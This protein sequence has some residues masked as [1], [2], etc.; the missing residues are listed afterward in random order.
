MA[1]CMPMP[2]VE[3]L[4]DP[5]RQGFDDPNRLVATEALHYPNGPLTGATYCH[6]P[7]VGQPARGENRRYCEPGIR[8]EADD[9]SNVVVLSGLPTHTSCSSDNEDRD[10]TLRSLIEDSMGRLQHQL[11]M[12]SELLQAILKE[13]QSASSPERAP[14][15]MG[16]MKERPNAKFDSKEQ[17]TMSSL[18]TATTFDSGARHGYKEVRATDMVQVNLVVNPEEHRERGGE[19]ES[20]PFE[21][22]DDVEDVGVRRPSKDYGGSTPTN[23][24][25]VERLATAAQSRPSARTALQR[26][27]TCDEDLLLQQVTSPT[28]KLGLQVVASSPFQIFIVFIILVNAVSDGVQVNWVATH[29]GESLPWYFRFLGYFY[30]TVFCLELLLKVSAYRSYFFKSAENGFWNY[31]DMFIVLSSLSEVLL[32]VIS[33]QGEQEVEGGS[34][35][36]S[37]RVIRMIRITRLLRVFRVVRIVRF[38]RAL[39]T[40]VYSITCTMKSVIWAFLLIMMIVYVFALLFTQSV[41]DFLL[42]EVD[43]DLMK[44]VLGSAEAP[45]TTLDDESLESQI[46]SLSKFWGNLPRSMFTLFKSISGGIDWDAAV[47]PLA[48]ISWIWVM[49][50][51][52]YIA[53]LT[54]AVLNVI[55]GVFCQSAIE[56]AQN[57]A[58]MAVQNFMENKKQYVEHL[59]TLFV[60]MDNDGNGI[61]SFEE[62]EHHLGDAEVQACFAALE[63]ETADAV[64]LFH[65]LDEE[66]TGRVSFEAFVDGCMRLKGNAKSLD[67]GKLMHTVANLVDKVNDLGSEVRASKQH[68]SSHGARQH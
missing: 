27:S 31:L 23:A 66:S 53:F 64:K 8:I 13:Q 49:L 21:L 68:H 33:A 30:F 48:D 45:S 67:L 40:L 41:A 7:A 44:S 60:N 43:E 20:V 1:C 38:I 37:L 56:S 3:G 2:I 35:M 29:I 52:G 19:Q 54:L 32:D 36:T 16:E 34:G 18:T 15:T 50:F 46:L 61:I 25:M 11:K 24:T 14:S 42:N 62:F 63:L 5:S 10:A 9:A 6:L 39:R 59:R 28:R 65:L 17:R 12:Q 55:T 4:D 47:H 22:E 26:K 58:D 51:S 57:D